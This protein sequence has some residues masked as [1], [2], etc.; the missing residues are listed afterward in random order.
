MNVA[1]S[2]HTAPA[3]AA[4]HAAHHRHDVKHA[5]VKS[6]CLWWLCELWYSGPQ[7]AQWEL[8]SDTINPI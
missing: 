2:N 1:L 8:I 6:D 5:S 7:L 4:Q 3:H